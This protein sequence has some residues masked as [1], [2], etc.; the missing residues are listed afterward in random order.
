MLFMG[1]PL[2]SWRPGRKGRI[3][4]IEAQDYEA[5]LYY[6]QLRRALGLGPQRQPPCLVHLHSP[7]EFIAR[8]ND[9]DI[10]LPAVTTAIRLE[11]YS[12]AAA[13]GLLCPSRYLARQAEAH[14]GLAAGSIHV[15][16]LPMGNNPTLERDQKTWEQG[17][18]CY[19]GRLE[20]RKGVIEWI[21]AA[22]S[23]ASDYPKA[24]FEFVGANGLG[25]RQASGEAFIESRIPEKLR[26]RFLFRGAQKRSDLPRSWS[27]RMAV[28]PSRWENFPNTCVEAMFR[29]SVIASREGGMAE[30]I[31]DGRTGWLAANAGREGLARPS[32][33]PRNPAMNIA[34][35]GK[36]G[37][38]TDIRQMYDNRKILESHLSFR[39][40]LVQQ[41]A[42]RSRH[43]PVNLP[44][45]KRPPSDESARRSAEGSSQKGIAIV[46]TCPDVRGPL[47]G[48]L[49]SLALQTQK[50]TAVVVVDNGS[51]DKQT[52]KALAEAKQRGWLVLRNNNEGLVSAKNLASNNFGFR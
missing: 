6:F 10:G 45:S 49:E 17:T 50:P 5:P 16:P 37:S 47:E 4:I 38:S 28:V 44:W 32:F 18:I 1:R 23:V 30:M 36:S 39:T 42:G 19:V 41:G 7:T 48:C 11:S 2:F 15:I 29:P 13:D 21:D 46:V 9:W 14:Y 35:N 27:A 43:L 51:A 40:Q 3:D 26:T 33:S 8:H 25:T 31:E 24:R 52:R 22:V 12:I 34:G 20:R